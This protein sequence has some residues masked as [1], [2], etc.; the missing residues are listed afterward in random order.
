MPLFSDGAGEPDVRVGR[1]HERVPSRAERLGRRLGVAPS[2]APETF[3]RPIVSCWSASD[4]RSQVSSSM[5]I[6][7]ARHTSAAHP[8]G[9]VGAGD[10]HVIAHHRAVFGLEVVGS[11]LESLQVARRALLG[12][13]GRRATESELGPAHGCGAAGDAHE[14]VERV[15]RDLGVVGTALDREITAAPFGSS[16]SPP[17][18]GGSS[19]NGA[20]KRCAKPSRSLPRSS[21]KTLRPRPTVTVRF[22]AGSPIASPVSSGGALV[23]VGEPVR[24]AGPR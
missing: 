19:I 9:I 6:R 11:V 23:S 14:V 3:R 17:P 21:T 5:R 22:R 20:G 12:A 13:G 24:P 15:E 1:D 4:D 8:R 16:N 2:G 10:P 7:R 18:N